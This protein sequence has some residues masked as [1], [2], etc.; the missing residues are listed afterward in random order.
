[1][2]YNISYET[3][4][5]PDNLPEN[6]TVTRKPF[7]LEGAGYKRVVVDPRGDR[8]Y[9]MVGDSSRPLTPEEATEVAEALQFFAGKTD[10]VVYNYGD[11]EPP[12]SVTTLRDN[13]DQLLFRAPGHHGA[14]YTYNPDRIRGYWTWDNL[15]FAFP[16][17]VVS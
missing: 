9:L 10:K 17:T 6:A 7:R 8:V 4:H 16:L 11:P 2:K 15:E 13:E 12:E 14:N 1:M 3:D 5:V